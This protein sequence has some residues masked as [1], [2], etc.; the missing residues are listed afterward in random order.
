MS[1]KLAFEDWVDQN[2]ESV[3][4]REPGLSTGD[5]HSGTIFGDSLGVFTEGERAFMNQAIEQGFYPVFR[6]IEAADE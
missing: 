1:I 3:Y 2:G 4:E 6:V 5:F